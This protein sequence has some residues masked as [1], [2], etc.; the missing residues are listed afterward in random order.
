[1]SDK[2]TRL[3]IYIESIEKHFNIIINEIIKKM[4]VY[5]R[6]CTYKVASHCV[7]LLKIYLEKH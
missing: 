1:M 3:K 7:F 2:C 6:K 5:I 4:N